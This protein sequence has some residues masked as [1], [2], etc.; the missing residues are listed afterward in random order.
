MMWKVAA[1]VAAALAAAYLAVGA[2]LPSEDCEH[3][4]RR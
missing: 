2:L 1:A 4:G 3:R